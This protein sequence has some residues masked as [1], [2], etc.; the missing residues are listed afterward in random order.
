MRY[1]NLDDTIGQSFTT[2][3]SQRP[4]GKFV[5]TCKNV[6]LGEHVSDSQQ[7]ASLKINDAI[8]T[9]LKTGA[10]GSTMII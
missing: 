4:D 6:D 3:V 7:G 2:K 5:A 1:A 10:N 8:D 9:Y